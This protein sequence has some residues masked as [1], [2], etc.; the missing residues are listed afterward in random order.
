MTTR[1]AAF[2][3]LFHINTS[4]KRRCLR[5][6]CRVSASKLIFEPHTLLD[7]EIMADKDGCGERENERERESEERAAAQVAIKY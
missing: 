2:F 7:M 1:E 5:R 3:L 6:L 4:R